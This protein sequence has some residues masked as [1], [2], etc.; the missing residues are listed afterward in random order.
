MT[1]DGATCLWQCLW[2]ETDLPLMPD[3]EHPYLVLWD[4]ESVQRDVPRPAEGNHEFPN[5]AVHAPPEQRVRGQVFDGRADGL[6]RRDCRVRV[7]ACQEPEGAL[8]VGQ[9][10]RR[11]DYR[12]HGFGRAAS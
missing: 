2:H 3:R 8:E 1:E 12:R 10:P 6:G 5:V 11:I 4:D 9:R 7:L